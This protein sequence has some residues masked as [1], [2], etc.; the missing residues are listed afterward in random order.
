MKKTLGVL[1]KVFL[2]K[3]LLDAKVKFTSRVKLPASLQRS[4]LPC[5]KDGKDLK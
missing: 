3:F 4:F 2:V 5:K 1:P